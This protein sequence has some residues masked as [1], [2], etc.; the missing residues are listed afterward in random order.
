MKKAILW[1]DKPYQNNKVFDLNNSDLNRDNCLIPFFYLKN[2]FKNKKINLVTQD[3]CSTDNAD[4]IIFSDFP[5]NHPKELRLAKK[6]YL[7]IFESI[8]IK[9][10]N[11]NILNYKFFNKVFTWCDIKTS[12]SNFFIKT[13]LSY[14]FPELNFK[15]FSKRFRLCTIISGNKIVNHPLELYSK[16]IEAIRWFEKNASSDFALYGRGWDQYTFKKILKPLNR[17]SFLRKL[18]LFKKY[19]SY[20]GTVNDKKSVLSNHKFSICF[21][22]AKDI[23]G[24]IT[25]KI[26]D[27]FFAGCIPIYW[28]ANN[29]ADHIPENTF[30]DFK[31]F[32]SYHDLHYFLKSIDEPQ[33]QIY[34]ENIKDFLSS[35]K[36]KQF[37]ASYFAQTIVDTILKN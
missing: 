34:Q 32:S 30:I 27:C 15:P 21:E 3:L 25:E 20:Q 19:P 29:I 10:E 35:D 16:R 37:Q 36:S 6:S 24:Y 5:K 18:F 1:V 12:Q 23:P 28:G 11:W 22:N 13:N 8:L 7:I 14:E 4:F 17:I 33:F 31:K 9:P 26:F 2:Y